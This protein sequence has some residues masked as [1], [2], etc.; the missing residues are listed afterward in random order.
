MTHKVKARVF[1]CSESLPKI[2]KPVT[3]AKKAGVCRVNYL[4]Y[5]SQKLLFSLLLVNFKC[6]GIYLVDHSLYKLKDRT[7]CLT[8]TM[9]SID[10]FH[11]FWTRST[12]ETNYS[13]FAW[14]LNPFYRFGV[15]GTN[16]TNG[17]NGHLNFSLIRSEFEFLE[18]K[19][20]HIT[21]SITSSA[22]PDLKNY[23]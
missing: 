14:I 23:D 17:L 8:R 21:L 22:S 4:P 6:L 1:F 19:K 18:E 15:V 10:F 9:I 2:F 5:E 13:E 16:E 11:Y 7:L 20:I 12:V 3:R